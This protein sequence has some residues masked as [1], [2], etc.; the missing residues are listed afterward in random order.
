MKQILIVDD[1]A[2]ILHMMG[3]M[4][5]RAKYGVL[6]AENGARAQRLL[7]SNCVDLIITDI[8]MPEKEGLEFI[9]EL[10]SMGTR[11]PIIAISGG[12]RL[13]P[14]TYL[15][16]A[17]EFGASHTFEKPIRQKELLQVVDRLLKEGE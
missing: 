15:D 10:R 4:L 1:D 6:L 14:T 11:V 12:A 7:A 8:V 3:R 16:I 2:Q 9:M 5:E 17:R 13:G